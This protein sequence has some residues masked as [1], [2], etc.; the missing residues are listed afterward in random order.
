[1]NE[2]DVRISKSDLESAVDAGVIGVDEAS[3]LYV[4]AADRHAAV[5]AV[6]VIEQPKGINIVSVAYYFG[7]MLMILACGWFL[8]D[9]WEIL[10]SRGILGTTILYFAISVSVGVLVRRRGYLN[11]G[12]ILITVA[13]C[14]VP[15]M[16][17]CVEDILGIWPTSA[18]GP[19]KEY[20]P[21]IS[22]A[23]V[24]MEW[25]TIIASLIALRF[26]RFGFLTMPLAF[27]FWFF[28]MDVASLIY[29]ENFENGNGRAWVSVIVGA[30]IIL[31]GY[32]LDRFAHEPDQPRSEDLAF[33]SYLFGLLA[34]SG[35]L[36]MVDGGG[37]L[38][39]AA[40]CAIHLGLIGIALK[41][42]RS[43]FL[44]FGAI[45]V[46]IYLGHLA[47]SVFANSFFFPFVIA[48]LGLSL[49]L[50]TVFAQRYLISRTTRS[51]E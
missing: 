18:H 24:A 50:I 44:V 3:R 27:S 51:S 12:G 16:T 22:G 31:I 36:S 35:G 6:P 38:G 37:E 25:L 29:G 48:L 41:L 15:L 11:A 34:F 40:Y 21:Y 43:V 47:Y 33:W 32:L 26:V 13:V 8:G 49:I 28:S 4:W 45:G 1:M 17:Y 30:L 20:Y 39:K 2:S 42:R 7:G 23:W 46:H 14:L 19:Y 9:K 10:G 5:E